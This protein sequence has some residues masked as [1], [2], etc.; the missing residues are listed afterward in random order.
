MLRT[1]SKRDT[2]HSGELDEVRRML[3]PKLSPEEGWARIDRA[4]R[5]A[6]DDEHWAAI[7]ET[8]KQQ[9]LSA[10]LLRQLRKLRENVRE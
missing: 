2:G 6:A 9:D 4:I 1:M 3:F 10:D 7:E 8:A 5:G